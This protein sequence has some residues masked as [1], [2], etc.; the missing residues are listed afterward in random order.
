[1]TSG[2]VH[3]WCPS[4]KLVTGRRRKMVLC[5]NTGFARYVDMFTFNKSITCPSHLT[6][7][8]RIMHAFCVN[9]I[10]LLDYCFLR[11]LYLFHV[12]FLYETLRRPNGLRRQATISAD[13]HGNLRCHFKKI[14]IGKMALCSNTG[15]ARY[16]DMFTFNKSITCPSHL[17]CA[18]RIMHAFCVN[19]IYL[20]DYCF[21]RFLYLFHVV[22]LYETLRTPNG[23]RRQATISADCH[24][25]LRCHFKKIGMNVFLTDPH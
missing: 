22:F 3:T 25:N 19:S 2:C 5:S 13:C 20:L 14:G 8:S 16:V 6:C 17:T 18:S 1:M 24:G 4:T 11:F 7:A 21:L 12:V 23:L 15:F 10:Y 9:S